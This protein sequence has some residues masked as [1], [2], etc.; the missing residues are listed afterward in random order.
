MRAVGPERWQAHTDREIRRASIHCRA[1]PSESVRILLPDLFVLLLTSQPNVRRRDI[2]GP[3][4]A[5]R[6]DG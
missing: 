6:H 2:R 4:S 5:G 3:T 1:P